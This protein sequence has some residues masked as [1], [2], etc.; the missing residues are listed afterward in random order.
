[1]VESCTFCDIVT[2]TKPGHIVYDD[3]QILAFMDHRP[4]N[5]GHVLVIPKEHEPDFQ[6]LGDD[7]YFRIMRTA[8]RLAQCLDQ[9]YQPPKVGLLI[10]G[11]H[12]PHTHIHVVPLYAMRD[13]TAEAVELAM[14]TMP[15]PNLLVDT[16]HHLRQALA[17]LSGRLHNER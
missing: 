14:R 6:C 11:F 8:K 3:D 13:I 16:C 1:M 5:P 2:G 12:V 17:G 9:M 10:V 7:I 4:L 15:D